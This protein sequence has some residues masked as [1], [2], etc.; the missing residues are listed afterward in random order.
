MKK[1]LR[2]LFLVLTPS[3]IFAQ[4]TI[5]NEKPHKI[6]IA[7]HGGASNIVNLNLTP[8][9]DS[10]YRAAMS[11]AIETGYLI[12]Q[13]GGK[14]IDAVTAVVKYLEDNP[15]FN[16][17]KGSVFTA[18]STIEMD[19]AIM[20]G[21]TLKCGAVAGVKTIKNPILAA[22]MILDSAQFIML[23]GK[24]AE[25]FAKENKLEI[26]SPDYFK[27]D[28]RWQQFLKVK[29]SDTTHLDNDTKGSIEPL[30]ENEFEKFGTVGCVAIDERG[31]LAAAT[32]TGGIVNKKYNRIGDSPIIGAGTYAN[33][34]TCAVSCTGK[35]EDFIRLVV[36][37]DISAQME[38][39]K[40]SL[41]KAVSNVIQ[42]K[43]IDKKG[44]G[45]CIAIDKNSN[46]EMSFTT[47]GMFRAS[48]DKN[49]QRFIGIYKDDK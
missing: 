10:A 20:G 23:S 44:R 19:A 38:Y 24:G 40:V 3:S 32:S 17:G 42:K 9:Q 5:M 4:D 1:I 26:V 8:Q 46:V 12:L 37:H 22:R 16:A 15:L 6:A 11:E 47:S 14:A 7:L 41:K 2:L 30:N 27:T 29:S 36:A 48:V 13:N 28:F 33:N 43:L 18:D 45:G 39:K 21:R 34:K 49:G 35:G 25:K 31:N